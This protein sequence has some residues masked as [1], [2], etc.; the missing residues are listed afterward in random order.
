MKG[1]IR[2][3]STLG[4]GTVIEIT[5]RLPVIS[6][7]ANPVACLSADSPRDVAGLRGLRVLAAD[8]NATNRLILAAMLAG[9]GMDVRLAENGLEACTLWRS[10]TF[11]VILL[12][13]SMPVMDG[14]EA[15]R[16]MRAEALETGRP[17]PIAIAAT[18]NVMTDQ[19]AQY[20]AEGFADTLPKPLNRQKL[21][22]VLLLHLFSKQGECPR[23]VP[24]RS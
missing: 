4:K 1:D 2:I 7:I 13:I 12:D 22:D 19:V 17:L 20:F 14:L 10:D 24:S 21:E 16:V 23:K 15:L 18:A 5:A 9:L 6:D 8:D 11:D 3:E